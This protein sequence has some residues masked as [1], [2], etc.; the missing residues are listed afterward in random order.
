VGSDDIKRKMRLQWKPTGPTIPI[1]KPLESVDAFLARGGNVTRVAPHQ[2]SQEILEGV[3]TAHPN[4][5]PDQFADPVLIPTED[6]IH[7]K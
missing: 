4:W 5:S 2:P 6:E 7:H 1:G 3:V